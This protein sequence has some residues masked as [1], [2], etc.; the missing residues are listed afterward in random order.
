M[1]Y[2]EFRKLVAEMRLAQRT[3]FKERSPQWLNES[4][5]ME[6]LVD[7]AIEAHGQKELFSGEH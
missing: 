4:K 7:K 3:Y 5:R 1:T 2:E 6:R